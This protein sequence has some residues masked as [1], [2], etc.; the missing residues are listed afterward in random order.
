MALYQLKPG[1]PIEAAQ[2]QPGLEDGFISFTSDTIDSNPIP[3]DLDKYAHFYTTVQDADDWSV[4]I[5]YVGDN[6][7]VY[8]DD[9]IVTPTVG[10][11][12]PVRKAE[13]E[14]KYELVGGGLP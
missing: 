3:A 7:P 8:P 9:Y 10:D 4:S 12:Y 6:V 13:F 11:K 1:T 2:Y 14:A 5:P